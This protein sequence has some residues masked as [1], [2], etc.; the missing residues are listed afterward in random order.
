M[1]PR[2]LSVDTAKRLGV[3]L[4]ILAIAG[5][6]ML[7]AFT[8]GSRLFPRQDPVPIATARIDERKAGDVSAAIGAA[9]AVQAR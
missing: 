9:T 4:A 6:V 7:A 2:L 5:V 1:K 3:T 8:V